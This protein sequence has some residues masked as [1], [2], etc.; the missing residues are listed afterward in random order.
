[1]TCASVRTR[2]RRVASRVVGWHLAVVAVRTV[3]ADALR[4]A[5]GR[6]LAQRLAR[7]LTIA[8]CRV[9]LHACVCVWRLRDACAAGT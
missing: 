8:V 7:V 3:G 5:S 4:S 9:N 2:A 6:G 1:M